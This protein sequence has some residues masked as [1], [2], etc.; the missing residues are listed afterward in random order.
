MFKELGELPD[1][2]T[3]AER[4]LSWVHAYGGTRKP[5]MVLIR[6]P[7]GPGGSVAVRDARRYLDPVGLVLADRG[8][9]A[10][11]IVHTGSHCAET[12]ETADHERREVIV[13]PRQGASPVQRGLLGSVAGKA[14]PEAKGPVLISRG[15]GLSKAALA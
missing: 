2:S 5:S 7:P 4:S 1:G 3:N 8:I 13:M 6:L 9:A 14:A 11:V 15:V 10:K 12:L